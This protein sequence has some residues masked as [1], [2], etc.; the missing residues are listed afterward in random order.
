LIVTA[1]VSSALLSASAIAQQSPSSKEQGKAGS[2]KLLKDGKGECS[3]RAWLDE[4]VRWI[5]T[6]IERAVFERLSS[7]EERDWFVEQFWSR[8]DPTPDTAE[9]EFKEEHYRRI[10]YSNVHFGADGW[11]SDRGRAYIVLGPPDEIEHPP[12]TTGRQPPTKA[13][14]PSTSAEEL[15]HYRFLEGIGSDVILRFVDSC[16][17]GDYHLVLEPYQKDLFGALLR[18]EGHNRHVETGMFIGPLRS[19]TVR[20]K[21]LEEFATHQIVVKRLPFEVVTHF[22]GM[23]RC[24][25]LVPIAIRINNQDISFAKEG[26]KEHGT[27]NVF[28]R[29]ISLTGRVVETFEGSLAVDGTPESTAEIRRGTSEYRGGVLLRPGSYRLDLVVQDVKGDRIGTWY[30]GIV[31]PAVE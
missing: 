17:C 1:L 19:P 30:H 23:T 26:D 22:M 13:S 28:G 10:A 8:R 9:N 5:I 25:V 27:V 18:D 14:P 11:K 16:K 21:E 24:T 6:D 2:R 20:F 31:V 4:D 15:W 29:L 12:P 7:D 3:Y